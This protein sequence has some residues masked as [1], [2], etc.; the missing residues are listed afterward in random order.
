[1]IYAKDFKNMVM[2]KNIGMKD[3]FKI[4]ITLK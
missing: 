1:M 2:M 3:N 4:K